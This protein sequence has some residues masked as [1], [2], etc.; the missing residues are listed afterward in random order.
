MP[1]RVRRRTE[2][3]GSLEL[4]QE[5][6]SSLLVIRFVGELLSRAS[7]PKFAFAFVAPGITA[8]STQAL[9]EAY[10]FED[11]TTIRR[12]TPLGQEDPDGTGWAF[13]LLSVGVPVDQHTSRHANIDVQSFNRP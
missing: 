1:A 7:R 4:S 10:S 11:P 12:S 5:T 8:F 2:E 3:V 9:Q 6:I 13:L